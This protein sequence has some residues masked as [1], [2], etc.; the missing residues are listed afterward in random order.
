MKKILISDGSSIKNPG[1]GGFAYVCIA[2][3]DNNNVLLNNE[4]IITSHFID[5]ATNNVMEMQALITGLQRY[6]NIDAAYTDSLYVIKGITE[7]IHKWKINHW[8]TSGK[9]DVKNKELWIE[10]EKVI[11]KQ[12]TEIKWIKGHNKPENCVSEFEKIITV[13]QNQV[14]GCARKS[15]IEQKMFEFPLG[16]AYTSASA[17]QVR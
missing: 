6:Q 4:S 15:A 14:D 17:K 1:P 13:I 16:I 7:W 2:I 11:A 5:R 10:L 9:T 3:D 12:N 8:K